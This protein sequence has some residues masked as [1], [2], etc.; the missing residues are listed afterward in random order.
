MI[1]SVAYSQLI[2]SSIQNPKN[3]F[4]AKRLGYCGNGNLLDAVPKVDGF[5]SLYPH[6]IG[7]LLRQLYSATDVD[8][9][10]LDDFMGVS[11]ITAPGGMLKWQ[12]RT[13]FLP[14][15]TAGQKPVFLNDASTLQAMTQNGFDGSKIVFLPPE[16]KSSVTVSNQTSAKILS[17]K[18]G[19]QTVDIEAEAAQPSLV[20]VAQTYYH[21]WRAEIDGQPAPLLRANGAFQAL[22]VP[23]GTH[24]IHLAYVDRAFETGAAISIA[25][26]LG[27]LI[28][29][30]CCSRKNN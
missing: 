26:W 25:A 6:D 4:L 18:F 14:L 17:S 30:F 10:R 27:S 13:N 8:F 24:K 1:A 23:A 20:V 19:N 16:M 7:E 11:Q 28:I 12:S 2:Y 21:D 22:Q 5:F 15:V 3:N 29:C 9:P